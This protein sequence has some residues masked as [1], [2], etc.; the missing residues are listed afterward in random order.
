[1]SNMSD[2]GANQPIGVFDSGI[3]GL[4]VADAI[5]K[6]LPNET[7][8]YF[9]DT[10]H[11][12]Y[13]DKSAQEV[14]NY[15][16]KIVDFLL[17][18]D[19]KIILIACNSASAASYKLLQ[20]YISNRAILINVIDPVINYLGMNYANKR[21]G[22]VGTKLTVQSG[23]YQDKIAQ[24]ESSIDFRA[25]A[26]TKLAPMIEE[27]FIEQQVINATLAEYLTHPS[28][29]NI[30]ALVLG[31]THYPVI[32]NI[33]AKFYNNT[34]DIIDA[35][36]IVADEVE[37]TLISRNLLSTTQPKY[38]FYVSSYTESFAKKTQL[39]FG[40]EIKV[41]LANIF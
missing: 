8:I 12:P 2:L 3:G 14:Q 33:I 40:K 6:Q 32:K 36:K 1:M 22:L 19:V 23:I 11:L 24:L 39:F 13:G 26:T 21:V 34:V 25:L 29:Q 16:K 10:A 9:G 38:S 27:N 4:T 20:N 31:C 30:D 15:A 41:E 37:S 28:L 7:I 18:R 35:G 5:I 17:S